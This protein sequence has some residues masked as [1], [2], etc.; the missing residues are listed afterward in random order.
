MQQGHHRPE[1]GNTR[2]SAILE[3]ISMHGD[4][5]FSQRQSSPGHLQ[6]SFAVLHFPTCWNIYCSA[7]QLPLRFLSIIYANYW[8]GQLPNALLLTEQGN[9][10]HAT[11]MFE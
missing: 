6:L 5:G 7:V 2:S 8:A 10:F 1:V 3:T 11:E 4:S 9:R